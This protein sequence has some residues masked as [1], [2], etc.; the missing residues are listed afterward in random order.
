MLSPT[1]A[2]VIKQQRC[3]AHPLAYPRPPLFVT[4]CHA[5]APPKTMVSG[6]ASDFGVHHKSKEQLDLFLQRYITGAEDM[7]VVLQVSLILL[8]RLLLLLLLLLLLSP[9]CVVSD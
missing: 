7:N 4:L 6:A 5:I 9:L 8:L 3:V 1:H 2:F